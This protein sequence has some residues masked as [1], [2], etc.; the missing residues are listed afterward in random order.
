MKSRYIWYSWIKSAYVCYVMYMARRCYILETNKLIKLLQIRVYHIVDCFHCFPLRL[1]SCVVI[2]FFASYIADDIGGQLN[3]VHN[4][5]TTDLKAF[6]MILNMLFSN[7][8]IE[9]KIELLLSW[10]VS[11]F[12]KVIIKVAN[13][14]ISAII[15]G[16]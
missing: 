5:A 12:L 10:E 11:S 14:T 9:N 4:A 15:I 8:H 16:M 7:G 2:L 1:N 6:W 13:V 3:I